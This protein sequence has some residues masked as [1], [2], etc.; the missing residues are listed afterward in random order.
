M[1]LN[2]I[3]ISLALLGQL[4]LACLFRIVGGSWF[5]PGAFFSL[6]WFVFMLYPWLLAPGYPIQASGVLWILFSSC[7]VCAGA[8][9]AR[10]YMVYYHQQRWGQRPVVVKQLVFPWLN[11]ILL[12]SIFLGLCAPVYLLHSQGY[13]NSSLLSVSYFLNVANRFSVMRYS[14]GFSPP[15]FS[16]LMVVFVYLAALLGGIRWSTATR[17]WE[18]MLAIC[19]LVPALCM[20]A[21]LTTK[22]SIFFAL[23]LYFSSCI[24]GIIFIKQGKVAIGRFVKPIIASSIILLVVIFV[25]DNFRAGRIDKSILDVWHHLQSAFAGH[26][27]VFSYWFDSYQAEDARLGQFTFAG[28]YHL[29][30]IAEREIGLYSEPTSL[31]MLSSNIFTMFRGLIMDFSMAGSLMFLGIFG[32]LAEGAYICVAKQKYLFLPLLMLFYAVTFWSFVVSI[33]NY[34]TILVAF[35]IFACLCL[36]RFLIPNEDCSRYC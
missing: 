17:R 13:L 27:A 1:I 6:Y 8:V 15:V 32:F 16:R 10:G 35:V 12:C 23:L 34:N 19:S 24:V 11:V 14:E 3:L 26:M 4:L 30:G 31:P 33:M 25:A 29:L 28:L 18:K 21:V 20:T 22:A 36:L 2:T 9:V 5:A 7:A